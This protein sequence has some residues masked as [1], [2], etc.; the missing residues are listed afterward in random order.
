MEAV[1]SVTDDVIKAL[2]SISDDLLNEKTKRCV[3]FLTISAAGIGMCVTLHLVTDVL[4]CSSPILAL[5]HQKRM[6]RSVSEG[7][8][9][10]EF[11]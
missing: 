8:W 1:K 10:D 7:L 5:G 4:L 3:C 9:G 2:K 11:F 6:S